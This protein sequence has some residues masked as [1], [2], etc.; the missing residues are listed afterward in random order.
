MSRDNSA[1]LILVSMRITTSSTALTLNRING[2]ERVYWMC[3]YDVVDLTRQV[4]YKLAIQLYSQDIEDIRTTD[5]EKVEKASQHLPEILSGMD[6]MLDASK[7]FLLG[8]WPESAEGLVRNGDKRKL[9]SI[10]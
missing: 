8:T 5:V 9:V 10:Y 1:I 7:E 6:K 3:R 2:T 4:L